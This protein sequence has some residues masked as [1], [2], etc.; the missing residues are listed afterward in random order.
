[1]HRH[2]PK[3]IYSEQKKR[4]IKKLSK[5]RKIE[6]VKNNSAIGTLTF[7]PEREEKIIKAE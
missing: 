2:L 5:Y 4:H 3:A 1:M 6:N 7:V